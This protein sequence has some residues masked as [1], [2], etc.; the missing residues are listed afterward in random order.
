MS[1][2]SILKQ[3]ETL[4]SEDRA[5][6][7]ERLGKAIH[8]TLDYLP[9]PGQLLHAEFGVPGTQ[10]VTLDQESRERVVDLVAPERESDVSEIVAELISL[11]FSREQVT[12][13][14]TPT[15]KRIVCP[16][17]FD[18]EDRLFESRRLKVRVSGLFERDRD[19]EPLKC[20]R[21]DSIEPFDLSE[22][23]L[24]L[25]QKG[26]VTLAIEPP[27][28]L[29]PQQDEESRASVIFANEPSLRMHVYAKNRDEL[30]E[31]A[32]SYV[33]FLWEAYAKANPD[34]LDSKAKDLAKALNERITE[35]A[36]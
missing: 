17:P 36:N 22:F 6:L 19:G 20:L 32:I 5:K 15:G 16:Y 7:L 2:D 23:E 31:E 9:R 28:R 34:S 25:I 18:D 35:K 24:A 12:V 33:F 27:L 10:P 26:K 14:Y 4:S 13:L 8:E 3:A 21:V 29:V 11:N 30:I 1:V